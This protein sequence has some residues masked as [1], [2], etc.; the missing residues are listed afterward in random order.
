MESGSLRDEGPAGGL[1]RT[2]NVRNNAITNP[3]R[4]ARWAEVRDL[5]W[6]LVE[7]RLPDGGAVA[8]VGAGNADDVPLA[9]IAARA[10]SVHLVDIDAGAPHAAVQC[11]PAALRERCSVIEQDVTA[12]GADLVL[13]AVQGAAELPDA[14]PDTGAPLGAGGYDLVIGDLL[15]TQLLQAGIAMLALPPAQARELMVRYDPVLTRALVR[16]LHASAPGGHV[17]H[18]HDLACWSPHHQQP[19]PLATVLDDPL[20]RAS[21]LARQDG[22]DP[23]RALA[24]MGASIQA[25][26]W[27]GWPAG[28]R[29]EYLV[30][31]TVV[32]VP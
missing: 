20:R 7:S 24:G 28:P 2:A 30:R 31:G 16:R 18:I 6:G 10:R 14:I 5:A 13:D 8:V 23:V 17:L 25:T 29:H 15:Y 27:W 19:L 21:G 1:A 32:R 3:E 26:A 12:G 11:L 4:H 22:C 9:R